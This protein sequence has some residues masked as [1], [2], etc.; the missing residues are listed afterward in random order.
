MPRA[1][2]CMLSILLDGKLDFHPSFKFMPADKLAET[3]A[4]NYSTYGKEFVLYCNTTGTAKQWMKLLLMLEQALRT[5]NIR[6]HNKLP[7]G[8]RIVPGSY[9]LGYRNDHDLQGRY[10]SSH[11]DYNPHGRLDPFFTFKIEEICAP[12]QRY[13]ESDGGITL[14]FKRKKRKVEILDDED[15]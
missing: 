14:W 3:K 7:C 13:G 12:L 10:I 8:D 9:Y 15:Q 2:P 5:E 6:S 1:I 4:A 11:F